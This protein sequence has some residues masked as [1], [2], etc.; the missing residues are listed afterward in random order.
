VDAIGTL[1]ADAKSAV[2]VLIGLLG[3][4]HDSMREKAA[5]TLGRVGPDAKQAVAALKTLAAEDRYAGVRDKAR[6]AIRKI[7]GRAD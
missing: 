7:T 4:H 2:P 6:E 5:E 1:G 3:H